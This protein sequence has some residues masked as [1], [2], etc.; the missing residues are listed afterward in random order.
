[1]N[2]K[3]LVFILLWIACGVLTAQGQIR[4]ELHLFRAGDTIVKQQVEYKDPGKRGRG[5]LWD[6]SRL[7][8]IDRGYTVVYGQ[9]AD[10]LFTVEEHQT[11]YFHTLVN[12][13]LFLTGYENPTTKV[14]Y[15]APELLLHFPLKEGEKTESRYAASGSYCDRLAFM[16][17]GTSSTTADA[18]GT[19]SLPDGDTLRQV[20]R[21]HNTRTVSEKSAPASS[22]FLSPSE[23]G[24]TKPKIAPNHFPNGTDFA[25]DS[26]LM[27]T[28]TYRW[29]AAG[30]RYPVF[31]TVSTG[32]VRG[33]SKTKQF[34]TAFYFPPYKHGYMETDT[35]NRRL[36]KELS[37]K[38]RLRNATAGD[39]PVRNKEV[40]KKEDEGASETAQSP[41]FTYKYYP[42]PVEWQLRL[43]CCL[44]ERAKVS[45]ALYA[46]TGLMMYRSPVKSLQP[47]TFSETIDMGH[48]PR[49]EYILLI[50]VNNKRFSAKILKK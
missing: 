17:C 35:E 45:M 49:G 36:H 22:R 25:N 21:V 30:Y 50:L 6:F 41:G 3:P 47:G 46:I 31:E 2:Y 13:S 20:I 10:S 48:F 8:T 4:K 16:T 14:V 1:M 12:D 32:S 28:D 39:I 5:I 26:A 9:T 29:Y 40:F 19:I 23:E 15:D 43:T 27:V 18:H 37:D 42:N 44:S 7:K 24:V 11:R 38:E 34:T 33:G